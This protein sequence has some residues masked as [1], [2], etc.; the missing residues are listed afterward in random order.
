MLGVPSDFLL[1]VSTTWKFNLDVDSS[2]SKSTTIYFP[3]VEFEKV[4]YLTG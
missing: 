2:S 1:S 3:I 4:H